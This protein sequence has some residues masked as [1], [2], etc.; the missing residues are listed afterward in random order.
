[1]GYLLGYLL[2][3]LSTDMLNLIQLHLP[4]NDLKNL[5]WGIFILSFR[6]SL[7]FEPRDPKF[8]G[9]VLASC[10]VSTARLVEI[11]LL[12]FPVGIK[13]PIL[14]L[15]FLAHNFGTFADS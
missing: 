7:W 5:V 14:G 6:L 8:Q 11:G 2:G 10:G 1:M 12:P 3:Y 9:L 4:W 15:R 13:I